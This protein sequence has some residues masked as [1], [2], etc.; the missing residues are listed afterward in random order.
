ML[1]KLRSVIILADSTSHIKVSVKNNPVHINC[2]NRLF[3]AIYEHKP[4]CIV[5]DHDFLGNETEKILRR[6]TC[7]PFYKDIKIYCYRSNPHTKVDDLLKALGV[8]HFIYAGQKEQA[9][10]FAPVSRSTGFLKNVF[11]RKLSLRFIN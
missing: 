6:L 4:D 5:L 8:Q 1:S 2:I 9:A 10:P 3:P 7:N 11:S